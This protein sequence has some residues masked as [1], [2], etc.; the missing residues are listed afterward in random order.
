MSAIREAGYEGIQFIEPLDSALV[1]Q[2]L[3]HGLGV[4]GSGRINLPADAERL[5]KEASLAGLECLTLHVG[6][7]YESDDEAAR[8][9]EA[10]L[11]SS[12]K[13]SIPLYVETHRATIFQDMWRTVQF[14]ARYNT[15]EFNG[16]FSHWYTGNEMV[17]GGFDRKAAFIQPV[18]DQ[19]R[20]MHGR[21]GSPGCMQ[22]NIGTFTEARKLSYVQHF[23]TLW[24]RVFQAYLRRQA[25]GP[26][27]FTTELL[28]ANIFYAREFHGEE[29]SDRWSQSLVLVE[30]ARQCFADA[31]ATIPR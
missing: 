2:A 10:I 11:S 9:I 7:G 17:Y 6:W 22:V 31:Q 18:I 12:S 8:L 25:Q 20:F 5:A 27:T 26:F 21:I 1:E 4:C 19:V 15:L 24:T 3:S 30:L 14:L 28:A 29:E 23:C 13:Y 16:D